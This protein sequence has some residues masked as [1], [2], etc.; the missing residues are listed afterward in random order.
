MIFFRLVKKYYLLLLSP[1]WAL[2]MK[3]RGIRVGSNFVCIG[4]P[5]INRTSG[6]SIILGNRV[7]LCSSG[8]A[9]PLAEK[10]CRLATVSPGA[11]IEL[12]DNV[13]LSSVIISAASRVEIGEGT[14][15]GGGALIID[16]DFHIRKPDGT[17]GTDPK[18]VS[19]PIVIGKNCFIGARA[20]ILK[21]VEI[22]DGAVIGAGAV[23]ANNVKSNKVVVGNP[24]RVVGGEYLKR[25]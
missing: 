16:T 24:A 6:S 23:V 9:N 7:T 12:S 20:I 11:V 19:S 14:I 1:L 3:L 10:R 2:I 8:M 25:T 17:W 13:G 4:R 21:G 5:G 18:A 15:V 22:G